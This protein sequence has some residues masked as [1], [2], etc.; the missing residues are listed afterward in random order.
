MASDSFP[1]KESVDLNTYRLQPEALKL[2][3]LAIALKYNLI[4]LAVENGT[5][6]VAMAEVHDM[7]A[8][9]E[10]AAVCKK[11]IVPV[12]ADPT[13]ISQAID[14]NYKSYGEVEKQLSKVAPQAVVEKAVEDVSE[15]PVVRA[16]DLI[17]NEAAKVRASDIHIEP[18]VDR[19][20]VR[21]RID[22]VLQEA[23]SLSLSAHSAIISRIK[24]MAKMNIADHR[25]QD[26]QLSFTLRNHGID[27]RVATINTIYG[28]M[29]TL[30]IL[31]KSFAARTLPEL[32]FATGTLNQYQKM[33]KSPLGMI[34]VCGPTG[35]GKTTTLY[36]SINNLD[37]KARKVITIE[38]PVEYRFPD[39]N[40]IQVNPKASITFASGVRSFMRHDPDVIMIGEIRDSDTA[41]MATQAALTGQLVLSSLH[42][43][44][45]AGSIS[46]LLDLG[47]GPYMISSTLV[48]VVSQRMARRVCPHCRQLTEESSEATTAYFNETGEKR[49]EFF[50]GRGC[51]ACAHTGYRGRVAI[52]EIMVMNQSLRSAIL[53]NAGIDE[54]RDISRKSGMISMWR[55]GMLKAKEGITTPSEVLRNILFAG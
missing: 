31:D 14:Y 36:A 23:M 40:Q 25:P 32:G 18:Q 4:P 38:D 53:K 46:R 47:I 21:Y 1:K 6:I 27:V 30:R 35:S 37:R 45:T 29:A 3:P 5:L 22:G 28:E 8:I 54:I 11:R 44:D 55:D 50:V 16:L 2:I 17:M 24:I 51:N 7:L 13:Q 34:L 26:G 33:L 39:I 9:Q 41:S 49:T 12:S 48:C 10:M 42:A 15:A 43:N 20:R 52:S 19:L